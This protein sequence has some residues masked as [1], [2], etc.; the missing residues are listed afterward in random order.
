MRPMSRGNVDAIVCRSVGFCL[1]FRSSVRS[2]FIGVAISAGN[3]LVAA[4]TQNNTLEAL[5]LEGN[6]IS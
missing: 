3:Y 6:S 5:S 2:L 1:P 4:A